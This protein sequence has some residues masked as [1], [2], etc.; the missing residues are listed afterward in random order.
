MSFRAHIIEKI[1]ALV[2]NHYQ[3]H[4]HSKGA[5]YLNFLQIGWIF[6]NPNPDELYDMTTSVLQLIL[7]IISSWKLAN[8]L[9]P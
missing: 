2:G 9:R 8:L 7:L 5:N 1:Q 3:L 6:L 4:D